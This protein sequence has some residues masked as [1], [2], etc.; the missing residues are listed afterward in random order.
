MHGIVVDKLCIVIDLKWKRYL[1]FKME[2]V[3]KVLPINIKSINQNCKFR[4]SLS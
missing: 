3:L 1:I 2:K 4:I